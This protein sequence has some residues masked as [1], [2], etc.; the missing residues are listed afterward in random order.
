MGELVF[1][2]IPNKIIENI[3]L[4]KEIGV[5][6]PFTLQLALDL[7]KRGI[8]VDLCI[9]ESELIDQLCQLDLKM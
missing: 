6:V 4:F 7:K 3:E 2:D 9:R 5:L 1:N 8:N